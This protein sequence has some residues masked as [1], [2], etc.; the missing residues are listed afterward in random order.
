MKQSQSDKRSPDGAARPWAALFFYLLLGLVLCCGAGNARADTCSAT[1]SD[2][3]FGAV[4]PLST[5]DI[6]VSASGTVSCAW[7]L[8]SSLP[9]YVVVLPNVSVCV[10]LGLG[11]GSSSLT[12]RTL[13]NGAAKLQY[14]LYSD[15]TMAP[16]A[17]AGS[18]ALPGASLPLLAVLNVPN[19]LAGGSTTQAFT[20]WGKIPAGA[21]LAAVATVGNADTNYVSSFAGHAS[22]SYAFYNLIKPAC[23]TGFSSSFSFTVRARVVNDCKI[24]AT[25]LS[26]GS[27]GTLA[28]AVRASSALSVQ[29]VNNNAYQVVLGGGSVANNVGA[30]KMKSA[31]GSTIGYRLSSSLDGPL[32]GDGS[33]GTAVWSAVGTGANLNVPIYGMVPA[34]AT[35]APGDYR[36]TVTATVVF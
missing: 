5:A 32:W 27:V 24:N 33:L 26:F 17:I 30:R 19:L 14:N 10:N 12:P 16:S 20:V 22:I 34:Q 31:A 35:P 2:V 6:S 13:S 3:N 7:S 18:T 25:P 29:C 8:L 23:T 9:P 15:A 21:A 11:D 28:G 36:D 1:L 4:S